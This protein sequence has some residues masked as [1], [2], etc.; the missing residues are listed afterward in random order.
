MNG[1]LFS[2]F[3]ITGLVNRP[4]LAI[5]GARIIAR[6]VA[7]INSILAVEVDG[8]NCAVIAPTNVASI[9]S[10]SFEHIMRTKLLS[11]TKRSA[12]D[13][14]DDELSRAMGA[15]TRIAVHNI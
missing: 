4:L 6:S 9:S 2:A 10:C 11:S 8:L 5:A 7:S 3:V 1:W 14:L 12:R 15:S 13:R